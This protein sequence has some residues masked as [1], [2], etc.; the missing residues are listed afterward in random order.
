MVETLLQGAIALPPGV[1]R[2]TEM[3]LGSE[4][5]LS[6]FSPDGDFEPK[7]SRIIMSPEIPR[8][9]HAVLIVF[10]VLSCAPLQA[11]NDSQDPAPTPTRDDQPDARETLVL[12]LR[13]AET[14]TVVQALHD[15]LGVGTSDDAMSDGVTV[16]TRPELRTLLIEGRKPLLRRIRSLVKLVDVEHR[17]DESGVLIIRLRHLD[18]STA[19]KVLNGIVDTNE[20]RHTVGTR[21]FASEEGNVLIVRYSTRKALHGY[22]EAFRK[23]DPPPPR[24]PRRTVMRHYLCRHLLAADVEKAF[25]ARWKEIPEEAITVVAHEESNSVLLRLPKGLWDRAR[26]I[27]EGIDRAIIPIWR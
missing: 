3:A 23:L 9:L 26:G 14:S 7:G 8:S 21:F 22:L 24:K 6:A 12:Q 1:D 17:G 16:I 2:V 5:T 15:V 27:L 10:V 4:R 20:E 18:A 13:H 19:A 25:R 11:Q